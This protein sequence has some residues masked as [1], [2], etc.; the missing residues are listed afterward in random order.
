M[1][2]G[3]KLLVI[4]LAITLAL[5]SCVMGFAAPADESSM[6]IEDGAKSINVFGKSI[7]IMVGD[8]LEI[9]PNNETKLVDIMVNGRVTK[10]VSMADMANLGKSKL[11][12]ESGS[13]LIRCSS[14]EKAAE[15]KAMIEEALAEGE[16]L[17][18]GLS[19]LSMDK[20]KSLLMDTIYIV[21][22]NGKLV[23]ENGIEMPEGIRPGGISSISQAYKTFV[24]ILDRML[25]EEQEKLAPVAPAP[26]SGCCAPVTPTAG[27]KPGAAA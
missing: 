20:L 1:K 18:T 3:K 25:K 6:T 21:D 7:V 27:E 22:A 24:D 8:E 15:M 5:S 16:K 10:G 17:D 9:L 4:A 26:S 14:K 2:I 19:G 23:D 13:M 11:V 12:L